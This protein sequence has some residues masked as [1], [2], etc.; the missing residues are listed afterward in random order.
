M[1]KKL[2]MY[3][4]IF[5]IFLCMT[6]IVGA[7]F[8]LFTSKDEV[9]IAVTAG[10]V[11]LTATILEEKPETYS[12]GVEQTAGEFA[13]GGT[14]LFD[15]TTKEMTLTN[16]TPGDMANFTIQMTNES[17]VDVQYRVKWTVTGELAEVLTATADGAEIVDNTSDWNFWD[18]TD[19]V[20]TKEIKVSVLLPIDVNDDYQNKTAD[21]NFV[22]E[23]VQGNA[24]IKEVSS[25]EQ[26]Q[27]LVMMGGGT[28]N[29][30]NNITLTKPLNIPENVSV[31]LNLN[32]NTIENKNENAIINKGTLT[33]NGSAVNAFALRAVATSGSIVSTYTYAIVNNGTME[34]NNISTSGIY[35]SGA[36]TINNSNV[37]NTI[38]GRHA[39]YHDGTSLTVN[40]GEFSSTSSN[41]LINAVGQN[42]M[43][44]AGT[45]TQLGKSY[46]FGPANAGIVINGGT[47]NGYVNEDGTN[48][49]MRPGVAVVY[50]GTFNFDSTSWLASGKKAVT[51]DDG[52]FVIVDDDRS[53]VNVEGLGTVVVPEN[54][55]KDEVVV[56]TSEDKNTELKSAIEQILASGNDA[57]YIATPGEYTLPDVPKGTAL[58]ISGAEDVKVG[59]MHD[60]GGEGGGNCDYSF[61][62]ST[63]TFDGIT[64]TTDN[65]TYTGY[66]R[67][68]GTYNNCTINGTYTL[69][70]DSVFN[71]CTFNVSGDVYNIWT[72]G[73]PNAT[74]NN[75]TFNSDGKALLLYGGTETVLTVNNCTFNDKGGLTDKKAA[76]EIGN[77]YGKSKT[78]IVNNT[79]VNGYEIND[80]GICTG[81][82]LFGDKNSMSVNDLL[83]VVVDG[84]TFVSDGFWKDADGN[85][86][87]TTANGLM[88][89]RNGIDA[90][91]SD[92]LAGKSINIMNDIDATG[93]TWETAVIASGSASRNGFVFNGNGHTISNLTIV[94]NSEKLTPGTGLF[95]MNAGNDT[96]TTFKD[97]TFDNVT[98]NGDTHTGI[99]WGQMYGKLVV[100]NVKVTDSSITGVC[101]VGA[102]VGRNGDD[103]ASEITFR[104]CSVM[105]TKV[106][107]TGTTG[108][109]DKAGA[110]AFLGMALKVGVNGVS[111]DLKFEGTN[112]VD[113]ETLAQLVTADGYQ[114]GGIYAT[115]NW[116]EDTWNTPIVV[117]DFTDYNNAN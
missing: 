23:A 40:G 77:D 109:D 22:V 31:T 67:M 44:N 104:N 20:R 34:I 91:G 19:A 46:L 112:T 88:T 12:M 97:I 9:N 65:A 39:I 82:T 6:V 35:N 72:W 47:Y 115:A 5:A 24:V 71:N 26:L 93:K 94:S 51:M 2:S 25:E 64:I 1:K 106:E 111:V 45:F 81:T 113:A 48:D 92:T 7:T 73:A 96:P 85:Y 68:N 30:V 3:S 87:I 114:G 28:A 83:T 43:L 95:A 52:K 50:G 103:S 54:V 55:S 107:A 98:V 59:V 90:W 14:A 105:N 69:Y 41:E 62:G 37:A 11:K 101:N 75:C 8:A 89:F 57:V 61:D 78:L 63:V 42:V 18:S 84:L 10:Q 99:L 15:S 58:T 49:K 108:T 74:F 80:K 79:I 38:S 116:G 13:N 117:K 29:L 100:D 66:V 56:L 4:S 27:T 53:A 17:N 76:I 102:L 70:G 36:M 16:V 21:I 32:G 110:S 33:I 60:H 86:Y